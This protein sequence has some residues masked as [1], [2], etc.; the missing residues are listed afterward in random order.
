MF[1]F[2]KPNKLTAIV[3]VE[4][5]LTITITVLCLSTAN[6]DIKRSICPYSCR[7]TNAKKKTEE[8]RNWPGGKQLGS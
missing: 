1:E 6:A 3:H 8:E 7:K 2:D 4:S 5:I